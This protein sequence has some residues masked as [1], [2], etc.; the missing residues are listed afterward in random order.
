MVVQSR[1]EASYVLRKQDVL[2]ARTVVLAGWCLFLFVQ[3]EGVFY[4]LGHKL[5]TLR[6]WRCTQRI[7][8]KATTSVAVV[9]K[10]QSVL[11]TAAIVS[12]KLRAG[13]VRN[14]PR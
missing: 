2:H 9:G 8:A 14:V 5:P 1:L 7:A 12:Y 10:M 4:G 13:G 3:R 6:S 11:H